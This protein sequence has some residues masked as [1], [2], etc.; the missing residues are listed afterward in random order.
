MCTGSK[1]RNGLWEP[2]Q[3]AGTPPEGFSLVCL[4]TFAH[5]ASTWR[6]G[7]Q[8]V[9]VAKVHAFQQPFV[10]K[11]ELKDCQ[12]QHAGGCQGC[13]HCGL[14][15]GQLMCAY[16][17]QGGVHAAHCGGVHAPLH[18]APARQ[19]PQTAHTHA[20]IQRVGCVPRARKHTK[21]VK[22]RLLIVRTE[23]CQKLEWVNAGCTLGRAQQQMHGT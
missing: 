12:V 18:E 2:V 23:N 15:A 19:T 4:W 10:G 5:A 16:W 13:T 20:P 7:D 21:H 22:G 11:G 8:S 9:S 3:L 6:R 1:S 17:T 14:R